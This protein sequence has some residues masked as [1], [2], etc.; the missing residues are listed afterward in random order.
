[1]RRCG[2]IAETNMGIRQ[3]II[4][5]VKQIQIQFNALRIC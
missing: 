3:R 5:S 1:M 2:L 4:S